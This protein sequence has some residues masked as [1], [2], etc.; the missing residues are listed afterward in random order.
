MN[1]IVLPSMLGLSVDGGVHL[2]HRIQER[3]ISELGAIMRGTGSAVAICTL[4]SLLG[5]AGML[6]A[7]HPGLRSIGLL[8]LIGLLGGLFGALVILPALVVSFGTEDEDG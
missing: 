1:A 3:G 4:T 8:A 5:F 2:Y 6:L 7:D